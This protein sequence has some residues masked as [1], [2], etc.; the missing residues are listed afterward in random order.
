MEMIRGKQSLEMDRRTLA[1]RLSA[2]DGALVDIGTGDGRFVRHAA[3][4][5]PRWLAIGVDACRENLRTGSR[6]AGPNALYVIANALALPCELHDVATWITINF[7][8]GSLVEG[9]LAGDKG[10]MS[11]LVGM[12]RPGA[13]VEVRLNADALAGAG[14]SLEAGAAQVTQRLI[15]AGLHAER[16][17]LLDALALRTL[18]TTWA[19]RLAFGRD[20]RGIYLRA[21]VHNV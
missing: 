8:W 7:P 17:S 12:A 14:V 21:C 15:A 16:Q 19:R 1:E 5:D 9:L 11:G 20:P 3:G 6:N 13:V 2:F 4:A 10:L 18:H